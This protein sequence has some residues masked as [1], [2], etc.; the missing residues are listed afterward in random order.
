MP[1]TGDWLNKLW[2]IPTK[3]WSAAVKSAAVGE[4]SPD[5]GGTG[6]GDH[7]LPHKYIKSSST[8]GA[9]STKQLPNTGGGPRIPRKA[10]QS[11][12]NE[13]EQNIK[14]KRESKDLGTETHSGDAVV[15]EVSTIGSPLSVLVSA[16]LWNLRRQS[17][18]KKKK[19]KKRNQHRIPVNG[20]A[21]WEVAHTVASASSWWGWRYG[22]Q[23]WTFR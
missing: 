17:N 9:I 3:E 22:L 18:L 2:N 11:L 12:W 20:N 14:T 10:N 7:F 15:K 8:C 16:E 21:Q 19:E 4:A 5:G 6:L 1:T 13:V 23:H